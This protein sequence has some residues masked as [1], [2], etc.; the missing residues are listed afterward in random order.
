MTY[1]LYN[2]YTGFTEE[3]P[4]TARGIAR[5]LICMRSGYHSTTRH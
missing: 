3:H 1:H 5:I 4:I 2:L